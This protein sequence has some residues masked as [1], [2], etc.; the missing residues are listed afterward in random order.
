MEFKITHKDFVANIK[1]H[2]DIEYFLEHRDL[3]RFISQDNVRM[4]S[5]YQD[6]MFES[7]NRFV[8]GDPRSLILESILYTILYYDD[9]KDL[10]FLY[11]DTGLIKIGI[12]NDV[13]RRVKEVARLVKSNLQ[14]VKVLKD[15]SQY[16]KT[17]HQIFSDINIP[18]MNQTEWFHPTQDLM[19]FISKL[20]EKNIT[21]LCQ[22]RLKKMTGKKKI[23]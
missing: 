13:D 23:S 21:K 15:S 2:C 4:L 10:Y 8:P 17:L 14:I 19:S 1:L 18:Y 5:K 9:N 20:N 6:E 12:S 11:S 16:E 22:T 3:S 7:L